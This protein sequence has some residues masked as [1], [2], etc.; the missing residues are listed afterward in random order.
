M[1]E[2]N[3]SLLSCNTLLVSCS[4]FC[5]LLESR[6]SGSSIFFVPSRW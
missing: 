4:L 3:C 1:A 5:P 6:C 2:M